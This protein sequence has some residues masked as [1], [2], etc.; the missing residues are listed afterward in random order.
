MKDLLDKSVAELNKDLA[1]AQKA[2]RELRF[3]GAGAKSKNTAQPKTLKH[4]IA[5]INFAL[6]KVVKKA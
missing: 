4:K 5:Q 3:G 2:L 6:A 1:E